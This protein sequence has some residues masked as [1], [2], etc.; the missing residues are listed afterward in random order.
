MHAGV[1]G[2]PLP[3][4]RAFTPR[5]G[6]HDTVMDTVPVGEARGGGTM[7]YIDEDTATRLVAESYKD[8]WRAA[9]DA[10]FECLGH[11]HVALYPIQRHLSETI[12]A[13][14][15]RVEASRTA[16]DDV[17]SLQ[18]LLEEATRMLTLFHTFVDHEIRKGTDR[19]VRFQQPQGVA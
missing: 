8:G 11:E 7:H 15:A 2:L 5:P 9:C 6:P 13:F 12:K 10:V 16:R 1:S 14:I 3:M 19:A 4:T 17:A 18:S